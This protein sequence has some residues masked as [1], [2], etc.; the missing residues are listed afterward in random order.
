MLL[1]PNCGSFST[2]GHFF[3]FFSLYNELKGTAAESSFCNSPFKTICIFVRFCRQ[4]KTGSFTEQSFNPSKEI[5]DCDDAVFY[6][7]E[8]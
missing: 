6:C 1:H 4:Q 8:E 5:D 2:A 3:L 7:P